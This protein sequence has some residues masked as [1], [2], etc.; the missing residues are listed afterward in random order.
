V[1]VFEDE[2]VATAVARIVE[3]V[4]EQNRDRLSAE[5]AAEASHGT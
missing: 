1:K 3:P 2:K 5:V 4:N